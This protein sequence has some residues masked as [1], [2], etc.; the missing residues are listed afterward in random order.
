VTIFKGGRLSRTGKRT[1]L[2]RSFV[3][4]VDYLL[5]GDG[6][7][8][9]AAWTSTVNLDT[10]DPASAARIMTADAQENPR[11]QLPVYHFG[12]S[13]PEGEHLDEEALADRRRARMLMYA[14][15]VDAVGIVTGRSPLYLLALT[16]A[17]AC[18]TY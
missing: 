2:G 16:P 11:V 10:E 12:L 6:D 13:L 4:L 7:P 8:D 18:L 3:Q 17:A 9:R 1:G 14:A 5:H 15:T